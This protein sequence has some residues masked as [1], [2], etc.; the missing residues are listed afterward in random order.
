MKIFKR[1]FQEAQKTNILS[2]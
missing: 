2:L 1:I